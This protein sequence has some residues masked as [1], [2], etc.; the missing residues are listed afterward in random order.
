MDR[1]LQ[2]EAVRLRAAARE[3]KVAL[4]SAL[5]ANAYT[6]PSRLGIGSTCIAPH[7]GQIRH[8]KRDDLASLVSE[9]ISSADLSS[10]Q[11]YVLLAL[12]R[13]L[14]QYEALLAGL[15][16]GI[17]RR[18]WPS[19]PYH[20]KLDLLLA[21]QMCS[22]ASDAERL[23]I[24]DVLQGLPA[25]EPIGVSSSLIDALKSLGALEADE[26]GL[27]GHRAARRFRRVLFRSSTIPTCGLWRAGVWFAQFDHPYEGAYCEAVAELS[28]EEN[29][30]LLVMAAK[31][32][33]DDA[34]FFVSV[35]ITGLAAYRDPAL[36]LIISRWDGASARRLSLPPQAAIAIFATAHI[37]LA[38]SGCPLPNVSQ[39]RLSRPR[40]FGGGRQDASTG[41][42]AQILP[43]P[44][45]R[46]ACQGEL[47][48]ALAPRAWGSRRRAKA[49][50]ARSSASRFDPLSRATG[51]IQTV[52]GNVFSPEVAE[53]GR[54]ALRHPE[55]QSGYFTHSGARRGA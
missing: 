35:L 13:H 10:G 2:H 50:S 31:G 18:H 54:E 22:R 42:T 48:D 27:H 49:A 24:I 12:V 23:A 33:S 8:S 39:N 19:A 20:L 9:R 16:P 41:S 37:A 17:L 4:R 5:F 38:R 28:E 7:L 55:K 29:K 6:S 1:R 25:S 3:K 44:A 45:R 36:G 43:T 52:I 21:A 51:P 53:I 40:G 46:A 11:L 14:H 32:T 15:L 30:A 34:A 47:G 26:F